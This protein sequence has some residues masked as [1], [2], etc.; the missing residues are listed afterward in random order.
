MSGKIARKLVAAAVLLAVSLTTG[1]VARQATKGE[2][3]AA[4]APISAT[5]ETKV[6]HYFGPYPNW[7]NSPQ[8]LANAVVK[9]GLGTP[10]PIAVGNPLTARA[11]ATDYATPPGVLAPV[12]A[13]LPNAVLPNGSLQSFQT[14]NQADHAGSPTPSAGGVFHAYV[15]R[16]T[17]TPSQ[18]TVV[19]DSG[20]LTVP[21]L[22]DPLVSEVATFPVA[23]AVAVQAGDVLGFYGQ[24]IPVDTGVA[25]N[26][27]LLSYPA[28]TD[29]TLATNV[30]PAQDATL[31]LGVDPGFPLYATQD[32]TYSLSAMVTPTITDPGTGAEATATVDPKTG[33]ISAV[34]V[35]S[36]GAGYV[37]APSVS[38]TSPGVNP[39]SLASATAQI[40]TG[41]ITD[42]TVN[43]AGYGFT[44]P[45]V[46]IT[47]G[48]PTVP[49]TAQA[50]GG[51][52]TSRSPMVGA[53]T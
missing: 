22:A 32:R 1:D 43:E 18:Y 50:S 30:A 19:Y 21:P 51:S 20:E 35:T 46:T 49:A 41:V 45:T 23:P 10:T 13:V 15:L 34:T 6:P 40:A 11:N 3:V 39:T 9:I 8:V 27:D 36:P 16:P 12:F 26:P 53:A 7:A 4:A 25:V 24:G 28:S 14:W 47:G 48:N 52:T 33:A 38:I 31:T 37:T 5:D 17:G 2:D 29:A 44:T 42:I